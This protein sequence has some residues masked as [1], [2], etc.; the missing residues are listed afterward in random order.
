MT[1]IKNTIE[2]INEDQVSK[3]DQFFAVD[4]SSEIMGEAVSFL[5]GPPPAVPTNPT[6]PIRAP[7]SVT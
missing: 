7:H 5:R 6:D 3:S 2:R 1:S 4:Q